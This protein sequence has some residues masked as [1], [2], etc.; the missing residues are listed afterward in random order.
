MIFFDHC[1]GL[2]IDHLGLAF[3]EIGSPFEVL[4]GKQKLDVKL[5]KIAV[6]VLLNDTSQIVADLFKNHADFLFY[7]DD[8]GLLHL[9]YFSGFGQLL[10]PKL[11]V[12]FGDGVL[13]GEEL[14]R[15]LRGLCHHQI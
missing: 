13:D 2:L 10:I 3:H 4:Q 8:E 15:D 6:A 1:L 11:L 9:V 7:P 5:L 12:P 14:I